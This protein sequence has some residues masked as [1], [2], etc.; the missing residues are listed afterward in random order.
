MGRAKE[1]MIE[2]QRE[3]FEKKLADILGI[4]YDEL[5]Q[6]DYEIDTNESNDG[7]VYNHIIVFSDDSSSDILDKIN[8]LEDRKR[9]WLQPWELNEDEEYYDEQ[10]ESILQNHQFLANFQ[11]ELKNLNRL[12]KIEIDDP[13]LQQILQRQIYI[14]IIG[15]LETFLFETFLNLTINDEVYFKNFVKSHPQFRKQKFELRE[16][17]E[18]TEKL[19]LIAKKVIIDSIY[20]D[21]P[22]VRAMYQATFN[23][24][25]PEINNVIK[26]V[27]TRHDLV[28]RNGKTKENKL[29]QLNSEIVDIVL[30]KTK[31]FVDKLAEKLKLR[32]IEG[33]QTIL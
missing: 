18:Q 31:E 1:M 2:K 4:T 6:L 5:S 20:H 30:H 21:L 26:Y 29:V 16:I 19:K 33:Q 3:N 12:N 9:V 10:Y 27:Q 15:T 25:F 32:D 28:H 14:G 13:S 11:T 17:F 8:G 7:L 24:D 23:I 22:R